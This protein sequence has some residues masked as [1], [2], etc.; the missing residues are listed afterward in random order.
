M[1]EEFDNT[2]DADAEGWGIFE[3]SGSANGR[4]QLCKVDDRETLADDAAAWRFV[5]AK[6]REGSA[7]HRRALD[8]LR[9]NAPAEWCS[10][11]QEHGEPL[12]HPCGAP[13]LDPEGYLIDSTGERISYDPDGKP[14]RFNPL[15]GAARET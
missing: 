11:G 4:H 7:Y 6:A 15:G 13:M 12:T 2:H 3:C 10:F 1:E 14:L 8:F 5:V 9:A